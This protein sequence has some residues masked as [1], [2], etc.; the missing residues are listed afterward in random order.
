MNPSDSWSYPQRKPRLLTFLAGAR[1]CT[2]RQA[3]NALGWPVTLTEQLLQDGVVAG[4]ISRSRRH[5][6][7]ITHAGIQAQRAMAKASRT[8]ESRMARVL[9]PGWAAS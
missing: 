4:E 6:Y 9:G 2:P 1:R 8:Y 5:C 7:S 3:A